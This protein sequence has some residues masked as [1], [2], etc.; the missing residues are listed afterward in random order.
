MNTAGHK[1][2]HQRV[3]RTSCHEPRPIT[4]GYPG[5]TGPRQLIPPAHG[6]PRQAVPGCLAEIPLKVPVSANRPPAYRGGYIVP[7]TGW[8]GVTPATAPGARLWPGTVLLA[9]LRRPRRPGGGC[10]G[11][12]RRAGGGPERRVDS[13]WSR[14]D[15]KL[16]K[17]PGL[18]IMQRPFL[19]SGPSPAETYPV[20]R[21]TLHPKVADDERRPAMTRL[22]T[23]RHEHRC[24]A[25][26]LT[27]A[28]GGRR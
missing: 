21:G 24:P 23:A 16:R 4:T 15:N 2:R 3:T 25:R 7:G 26:G 22:H 27:G 8:V 17:K 10:C 19:H 1:R 28:R 12:G 9:W 5:H 6:S 20:L 18:L 11:P 14:V 13:K